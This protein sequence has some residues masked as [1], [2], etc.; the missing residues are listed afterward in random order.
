MYQLINRNIE[1]SPSTEQSHTCK[2]TRVFTMDHV[3][4]VMVDIKIGDVQTGVSHL[5]YSITYPND[6]N[7][8]RKYSD[9]HIYLFVKPNTRF[10][11]KKLGGTHQ[12]AQFWWHTSQFHHKNH[13]NMP[14]QYQKMQVLA[15]KL[16]TCS[17]IIVIYIY[18]HGHCALID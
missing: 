14:S 13:K 11:S 16:C 9:I 2:I 4:M 12:V 6:R 5:H 7:N 8:H 15:P 17:K 18:V 3:I 10:P 1:T